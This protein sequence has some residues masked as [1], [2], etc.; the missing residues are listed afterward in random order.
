MSREFEAVAADP[1]RVAGAAMAAGSPAI[2]RW[3]TSPSRS[4]GDRLGL[5]TMPQ[6]PPVQ[7]RSTTAAVAWS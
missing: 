6:Q 1:D 2:Q 3:S 7:R 4:R 5:R